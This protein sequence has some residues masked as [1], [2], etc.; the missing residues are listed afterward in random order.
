MFGVFFSPTKK[1]HIFV[2]DT[3]RSNQMPNMQNLYN[4]E[5]SHKLKSAQEENLHLPAEN[6]NFEIKFET[7]LRH[8]YKQ[9][10]KLLQ[11]YRDEKKG[12]TFIAVQSPHDF[13]SLSSLIPGM[14]EFPMVPVHVADID[15]L[16]NVLDW[17]RVGARTMVRHFLGYLT[18]YHMTLEQSRYFHVPV[19]NLPSDTTSFGADLFYARHLQKHSCVLWCSPT[20]RPD[21]GGHEFNDNRLVVELEETALVTEINNPGYYESVCI[22]LDIDALAVTTLLEAH[23]INETEGTSSSIAFDAMPQM[24]VQ[25]MVGNSNNSSETSLASLTSYDETARCAS[26]FRILRQMVTAWLN[27]VSLYH[28]VFADFQIVHFYRWLRDPNSLLH[29]PALRRI[30]H[31]L[32]NK[33]FLHLVAEF[34]RLGAVIV[35]ANFNKIVICT[36]KKRV[37]DALTYVEYIVEAI[38]NKELFHS[39]DIN[40]N[41]CWQYLAW[42][43]VS[44]HGGVK[45][46]AIN[47]TQSNDPHDADAEIEVILFRLP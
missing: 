17:Q 13:L 16:Y 20:I 46:K 36:K 27:D 1:A 41:R 9:I 3:V 10:Q 29:D 44:N 6:F 28:N 18:I 30:L 35:F 11:G 15:G 5:R 2:V 39:I 8:V 37:A 33:L 38:K 23:H 19:G 25:D 7:E 31:T 4:A 26:A 22:E 47:S 14:T 43:D 42:F 12:P 21:L 45:G 34:K 24:S 32:M 40:L